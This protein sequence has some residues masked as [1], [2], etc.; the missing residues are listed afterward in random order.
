M[1]TAQLAVYLAATILVFVWGAMAWSV[2]RESRYANAYLARRGHSATTARVV[3]VR[4]P[5][6]A[7][8]LTVLEMGLHRAHELECECWQAAG[9]DGNFAQLPRIVH[10]SRRIGL[11]GWPLQ[12]AEWTGAWVEIQNCGAIIKIVSPLDWWSL[13]KLLL[14]QAPAYALRPWLFIPLI[15]LTWL[16]VAKDWHLRASFVAAGIEEVIEER[17]TSAACVQG[18]GDC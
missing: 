1:E 2:R 5:P 4:L 3:I 17:K 9:V 11:R 14:L 10:R 16:S 12:P 8:S 13:P 6:R 18:D 15:L 7:S